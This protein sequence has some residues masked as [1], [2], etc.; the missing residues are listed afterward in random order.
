MATELEE[1]P[2]KASPEALA[3]WDAAAAESRLDPRPFRELSFEE[4]RTRLRRL[5]GSGQGLLPSSQD[6]LR[7][8]REEV[9][10]EEDLRSRAAID[11]ELT[12]MTND[13]DHRR[14]AVELATEFESSDWEACE[15]AVLEAGRVNR[16]LVGRQ[17]D[18]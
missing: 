18:R 10:F 9:E 6:F 15:R 5:R 7:Q 1:A 13:H 3:R 2:E 12:Q 11:A 16:R 17:Q 8:K 4:R 14:E